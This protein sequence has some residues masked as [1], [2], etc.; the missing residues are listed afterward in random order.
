M[1]RNVSKY[2]SNCSKS[3]VEKY[4]LKVKQCAKHLNRR[5]HAPNMCICHIQYRAVSRAIRRSGRLCTIAVLK[6]KWSIRP[7]NDTKTLKGHVFEGK[8]Y[9]NA[10][11]WM[12]WNR[13][14]SNSECAPVCDLKQGL[15]W[16]K[17]Y[18]SKNAK[19]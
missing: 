5:R 9:R 7:K 10:G 1:G 14:V 6:V 2:W 17:K 19:M 16:V 8:N 13:S 11:M 12:F 4:F 15:S 18:C 3:L